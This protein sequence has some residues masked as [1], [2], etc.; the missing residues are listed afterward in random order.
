MIILKRPVSTLTPREQEVLELLWDGHCDDSIAAQLDC[1][2]ET[3]KSHLT[4]MRRKTGTNARLDLAMKTF[5][6]AHHWS[7][8]G[9]V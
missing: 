9:K 3:V 7:K 8:K 1:S 6:E 4:N 2:Y 5:K